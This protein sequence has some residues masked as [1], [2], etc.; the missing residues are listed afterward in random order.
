MIAGDH[1]DRYGP[2][3]ELCKNCVEGFHWKRPASMPKISQENDGGMTFEGLGMSEM[4][5]LNAGGSCFALDMQVGKQK[6]MA[7]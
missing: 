3:L 2:G 1:E 4:K 5:D 6:E 7:G